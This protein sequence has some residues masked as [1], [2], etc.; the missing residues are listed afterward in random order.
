MIIPAIISTSQK[1][2]LE[3]I[4]LVKP[5][6]K[7][8][9]IDIMDGSLTE[10]STIH[11]KEIK[12]IDIPSEVHFMCNNP[13]SYINDIKGSL[14]EKVIIHKEIDYFEKEVSLFKDSFIIYG[15]I[16]L[17]TQAQEI[18]E[19]MEILDGVMVMSVKIGKGGQS[20]NPSVLKKVRTLEKITNNI[21]IDGGITL[22]NINK[23]KI[24]GGKDFAIGSSIYKSEN[25]KQTLIDFENLIK[26][27]R[28]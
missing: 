14:A 6:V 28:A 22:G 5:Y 15:A 23:C 2:L 16:D 9:H 24:A 1:N 3:K 20:F 4:E 13:S 8:V 10:Y 12:N 7:R 27:S 25:I 19:F 26:D 11:P 21:E 18:E 17:N